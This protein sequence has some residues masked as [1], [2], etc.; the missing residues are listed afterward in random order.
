MATATLASAFVAILIS[1][2]LR[3]D[4]H[5]QPYDAPLRPLAGIAALL[6]LTARRVNFVKLFQW[7][8]PLAVLIC[9][10]ELLLA[11]DPFQKWGGRLSNYFVDPLSLGQY[12]LLLGVLSAFMI[13]LVEKDGPIAVS[14]PAPVAGLGSVLTDPRS[15]D[16]HSILFV[17]WLLAAEFVT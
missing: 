1:Q 6:Y 16:R 4:F 13:N 10:A 15:G 11:P 9:A 12:M 17:I 14:W 7:T 3:W 8:C 2:T 5:S